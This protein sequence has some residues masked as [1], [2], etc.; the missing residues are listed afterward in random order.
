VPPIPF[1]TCISYSYPLLPPILTRGVFLGFGE[2]Y[3]QILGIVMA[4]IAVL[5]N[6]YCESLLL[7]LPII[8]IIIIIVVVVITLSLPG[9]EGER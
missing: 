3:P 2:R 9:R 1:L 4:F 7:L 5:F 6:I 8:I